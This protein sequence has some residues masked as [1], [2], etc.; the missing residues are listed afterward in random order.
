MFDFLKRLGIGQKAFNPNVFSFFYN[1]ASPK[2]GE[3]QLLDAY[4]GMVFACVN[5]IAEEVGNIHLR[6]QRKTKDSWEEIPD[7]PALT[8]LSS[9]NNFTTSSDLLIGTQAFLELDGNAFWYMVRNGNSGGGDLVEI[10]L[11]DPTRMSIVKN[12]TTIISNYVYQNEKGDKVPME[13]GEI[14]HFKRFNPKD[15]YRGVGTVQAA[16]LPIDIDD[17]SAQWQRNFFSNAAMPSGILS[18]DGTLNQEQYDRIKAN[19]DSKYKGVANSSKMA[20]L[21]GGLHFTPVNFT[22]REMQ[23][24]DGRRAIRDEILAIFRVPKSI[25]GIV[26]D[27]NRA[28]AEASDYVFGKRV[29]KPKMQFLVDK[30]N[31]FYL[32]MFGL[33]NSQYRFDFDDP[34]PQNQDLLMTQI[35]KGLNGASYLTINEARE[36]MGYPPLD[37]G[38]DEIFISNSVIPLGTAIQSGHYTEP[39]GLKTREVKLKKKYKINVQKRFVKQ[40]VYLAEQKVKLYKTFVELNAKL[41]EMLLANLKKKK[42]L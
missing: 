29:I 9:V 16:A 14:I 18:T 6:L 4:K 17:Y 39:K 11:L 10:W 20:L 5:A 42:T 38:G 23:F 27:V 28:N 15:Q 7:H 25:L 34:V 19:W 21:E 32:P 13:L 26:E 35:S 2:L 37:E 31:E 3:K 12:S 33:K 22:Q 1:Q 24:L 8:L 41:K 36:Q 40:D 30:L